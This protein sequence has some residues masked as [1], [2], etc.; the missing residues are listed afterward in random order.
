MLYSA[1]F[2]PILELNPRAQQEAT[3]RFSCI[4]DLKDLLPLAKTIP[5]TNLMLTI[6][7]YSLCYRHGTRLYGLRSR[8]SCDWLNYVHVN[9]TIKLLM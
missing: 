1:Q 6:V 5:C 7:P 4:F 2:D 9:M 8:D 3:P